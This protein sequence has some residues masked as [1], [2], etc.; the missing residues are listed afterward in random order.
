MENRKVP[1]RWNIQG[2]PYEAYYMSNAGDSAVH[3]HSHFL[4]TL[5]REGK[6]RQVLNGNEYELE[7]GKIILMSPL[8]FH[9]NK[10][11][12]PGIT[13]YGVK[14]SDAILSEQMDE[15]VKFEYFPVVGKLDEDQFR[16]A[17][18]LFEILLKEQA[19]PE[20][21]GSRVFAGN[22][23]E[24]LILLAFRGE[25][26]T[27]PVKKNARSVRNALMYIHEHFRE[28]ISVESVA[29]LI[30]YSPNHFSLRFREVTG[31]TFQNYLRDVRL[32]F[33]KRLLETGMSVTEAGYESG[34]GSAAYFS[35]SF[36][37]KHGCTPVRY[38]NTVN[39]AEETSDRKEKEERGT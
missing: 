35:R 27:E 28:K 8:D 25:V 11:D 17:E 26:R 18:Y 10:T 16:T 37:K 24:Q 31:M 32:D 23:I 20:Q 7:R 22:L 1:V 13:Y 15:F 12:G 2:R 9:Y 14:F 5:M 29:S 34:F 33:S 6:G 21:K 19:C 39:C 3:W 4:L 38:R 30:H 36:K